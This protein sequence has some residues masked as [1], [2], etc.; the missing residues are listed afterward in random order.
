[1][2]DWLTLFGAL[3]GVAVGAWITSATQARE[4][5]EA[6]FSR[7]RERTA[8]TLA[9]VRVLLTD[10]NPTRLGFNFSHERWPEILRDLWDLCRPTQH[11]LEVLH[12]G[13]PRPDIRDPAGRL[14][15]ALFN[16]ITSAGWLLRDLAHMSDIPP[17]FQTPSPQELAKKDHAEA[18]SLA[19]QIVRAVWDE[20]PSNWWRFRR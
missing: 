14:S 2:G 19:T 8:E 4:R 13:H 1:M 7:W 18:E 5:R 9:T 12:I 6:E 3:G 10:A 15:V 16:A 20:P 11:S 17:G